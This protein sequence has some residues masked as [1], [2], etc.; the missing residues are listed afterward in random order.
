MV[1]RKNLLGRCFYFGTR[2]N[3]LQTAIITSLIVGTILNLIN[4]F[5]NFLDHKP[6]SPVKI[7]LN[8]LTPYMVT[9]V[10]A[11]RMCFQFENKIEK[12]S[13]SESVSDPE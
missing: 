6:L 8:Y 1:M 9:T 13:H 7:L 11:I 5:P 2:R 10:G 4:Q 12:G 3:V